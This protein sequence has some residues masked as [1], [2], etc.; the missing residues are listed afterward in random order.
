MNPELPGAPLKPSFGLSGIVSKLN[1]SEQDWHYVKSEAFPLI[2]TERERL[3]HPPPEAIAGGAHASNSRTLGTKH[4]ASSP[5]DQHAQ[6]AVL[7][8]N[9]PEL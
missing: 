6:I 5:L 4:P 8:A 2:R 7:I 3:G 9:P 1:Q